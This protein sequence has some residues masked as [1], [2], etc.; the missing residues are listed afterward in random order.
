MKRKVLGII[1]RVQKRKAVGIIFNI[2]KN[3]EAILQNKLLDKKNIVIKGR[4]AYTSAMLLYRLSNQLK[5]KNLSFDQLPG[6]IDG[7][8]IVITGA[9]IIKTSYVRV[10]DDSSKYKIPVLLLMRKDQKMNDIRK[11]PV[12]QRIFTIEQNYQSL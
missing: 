10:L 8:I 11:S 6:I 9:D 12:Y 5:I 2:P 1:E 3:E 4:D 7:K